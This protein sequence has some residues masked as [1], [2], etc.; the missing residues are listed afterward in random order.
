MD[1][2]FCSRLFLPSLTLQAFAAK[3]LH[4]VQ[5]LLLPIIV[6]TGRR[7]CG[8]LGGEVPVGLIDKILVI[9]C[10]RCFR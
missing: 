8:W 9:S 1:A 5:S 4:V 10:H 3:A 2:A 6:L 7:R